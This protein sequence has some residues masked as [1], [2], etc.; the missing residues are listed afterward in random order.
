MTTEKSQVT[1]ER[2]MDAAEVLCA[3]AVSEHSNK[4]DAMPA[5]CWHVSPDDL[6]KWA[7]ELARQE[8]EKAK[9]E[10]QI[11]ELAAE[12]YAM[13]GGQTLWLRWDEQWQMIKSHWRNVARELAGRYPSILQDSPV[14]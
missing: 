14:Q 10:K 4:P 9:R 7:G 3:F 5:R 1:P 8:D 2:A 13:A 6:T 11:E 12:L